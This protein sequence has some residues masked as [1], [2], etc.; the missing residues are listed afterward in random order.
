MGIGDGDRD[1][2]YWEGVSKRMFFWFGGGIDLVDDDDLMRAVGHFGRL[3]L[4]C[5]LLFRVDSI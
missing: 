5:C 4:L 2:D 3:E 1:G